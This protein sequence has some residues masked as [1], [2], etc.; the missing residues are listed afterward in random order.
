MLFKIDN[1]IIHLGVI[2]R[3]ETLQIDIKDVAINDLVSAEDPH[4]T[5]HR[6]KVLSL[7]FTGWLV[8]LLTKHIG[9]FKMILIENCRFMRNHDSKSKNRVQNM[10][11]E[12]ISKFSVVL[13]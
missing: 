12:Q 13:A 8:S 5:K 11:E 1:A 9:Q 2:R 7:K 10:G 4:A 3:L 6:K